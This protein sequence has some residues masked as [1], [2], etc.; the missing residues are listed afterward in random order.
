MFL[1][2][3]AIT[4]VVR[5]NFFLL[6]VL[7][8]VAVVQAEEQVPQVAVLHPQ[9]VLRAVLLLLLQ[10]NAAAAGVFFLVFAVQFAMQPAMLRLASVT[11][12]TAATV[13]NWR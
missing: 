10:V 9:R 4:A 5:T 6:V 13:D 3:L 7:L 12:E 1:A 8:S 2:M 11:V